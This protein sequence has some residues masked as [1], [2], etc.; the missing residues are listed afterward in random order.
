MLLLGFLD[1]MEPCSQPSNFAIRKFMV[2]CG[3][4]VYV[5]IWIRE[6]EHFLTTFDGSCTPDWDY[7]GIFKGVTVENSKSA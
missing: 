4:A 7:S 2:E 1:I 6:V 5:S 3:G